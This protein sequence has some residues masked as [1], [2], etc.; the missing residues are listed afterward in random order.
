MR[1]VRSISTGQNAV[2][3]LGR[4]CL[5]TAH[6]SL[7]EWY[8]PRTRHVAQ[9]RSSGQRHFQTISVLSVAMRVKSEVP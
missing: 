7:K 4:H 5:A 8:P 6:R 2:R 1:S 3:L 9:A